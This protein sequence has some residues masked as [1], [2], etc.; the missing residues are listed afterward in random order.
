M[1]PG[2]RGVDGLMLSVSRIEILGISKTYPVRHGSATKQALKEVNLTV[3]DGE[4]ICLLGPSGCGKTT[5]LNIVS[6]L[7]RDYDGI[8]RFSGDPTIGYVFQDARLLPW[9][10]VEQNLRFVLSGGSKGAESAD[11]AELIHRWIARVGLSGYEHYYPAQLSI[12]MQQRVALA[13]ALIVRPDV[14]LMDEPLSALDELTS[15]RMRDELVGLW[16]D[17]A[18]TVLFVTHNPLEAVYLADRVVVMTSSPGRIVAEL[19]VSSLFP[20]PRVPDDA[21][22]WQLSREA[23]RLLETA[24]KRESDAV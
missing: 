20:R 15:L 22:L 24:G 2:F 11:Q 7:E 13:R 14:L 10:T 21:R 1:A 3:R 18:C 9:M 4:F 23:V 6:G 8:V 17:S 19:D 5:L 12:G 16:E